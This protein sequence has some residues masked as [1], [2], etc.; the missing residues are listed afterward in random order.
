M[1]FSL[2]L[3]LLAS[4]TG[5]AAD[6]TRSGDSAPNV[7]LIV[8]DDLGYSDLGAWG[9]EIRTPTLDALAAKGTMLT[10][11]HTG[12]TCGPTR[13]ML[14]TGVDHHRA[15]IGT[16]AASLRRLPELKGRP[17]YEGF[18]NDRVVTLATLLKEAGYRTYMTGKWDLGGQPGKRPTERGFDRY[19][20]IPAAGASHFDDMTGTFRPVQ[21]AVYLDDA[22]EV[23]ALPEDFY[24][25]V[26]YTDRILDYVS[27]GDTDSPW[28]AYVAYTAPHWPLQVPDEWIDRYRGDYD[29]GWAEIRKS[30]FERQKKE[31]LL[32]DYA[33]LPA[34]PGSVPDWS[35]LSPFEQMV[36]ARAME[37][38]AAMIELMD[39]QIGRLIETLVDAGERETV[40]V[41]LSDNGAEGNDIGAILDNRRWI[42]ATFDNRLDNMGRRDSYLWLGAGWGAAASSPLRLYKSFVTEGGIRAPAIVYSSED[43]FDAARRD[44]FIDVRDITPTLLELAGVTHP[45]GDDGPLAPDGRSALAYLEGEADT[46]HGT[47]AVGYELYGNRALVRDGYKALLVWP[48]EGSGEWQLYRLDADGTESNDLAAERPALL[49]ELVREW[50]GYAEQNGVAVFDRD[51]GYGRYGNTR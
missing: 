2:L 51:L 6:R 5:A 41:F 1:R 19:F 35:A 42:P 20:G 39:A 31:G 38:Y 13:A 24:S 45:G 3:L 26:D 11:Y 29:A 34:L 33:E 7:L 43:R 15:G 28:F 44:A 27:E 49:E 18:L 48:P 17:G 22:D 47:H 14:M 10:N 21:D 46:V 32:A 36:E 23:D 25:T 30:R 8:A 9:G 40:V 4:L 37:V 50:S 12:P 16:N